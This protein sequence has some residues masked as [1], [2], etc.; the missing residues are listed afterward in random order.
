LF[1][2]PHRIRVCDRIPSSRALTLLSHTTIITV[3]QTTFNM[4]RYEDR[5]RSDRGYRGDDRGYRSERSE[6]F[7]YR[8]DDGATRLYVGGLSTRTRSRDLEDVFAKYGRYESLPLSP[9]VGW[10][11]LPRNK[12]LQQA[13][14]QHVFLTPCSSMDGNV[15][16]LTPNLFNIVCFECKNSKTLLCDFPGPI[17]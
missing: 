5:D 17:L 11:I 14:F 2:P 12:K 9:P 1:P 7:E 6:R 16:V 3:I 4:P 13:Q 8:G 15:H 10:I